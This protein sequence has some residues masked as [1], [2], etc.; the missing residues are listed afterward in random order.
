MAK[1]KSKNLRGVGSPDFT[2]NEPLTAVIR[3]NSENVL[4]FYID[5][6]NNEVNGALWDE[7]NGKTYNL[8]GTLTEES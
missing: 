1:A 2:Y 5:R 7:V 3:L 6:D 4:T 8:L